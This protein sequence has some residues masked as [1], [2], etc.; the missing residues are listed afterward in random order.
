[1]KILRGTIFG[2]IAYFLLG[3]LVYGILLM[4]YFS[5]YTNTC[6]NRPEGEMIWWAI[7]LSN[8]LGALFLS[9]FLDRSRASRMADGLKTGGVFGALFT[10]T[11]NFSFWSMSIMYSSLLPLLVEIL[12][13]AIV[14]AIVG[15]IIVLTWGKA[16]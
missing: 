1:M 11:I 6:A 2:G 13:S 14:Y 16:K 10:A 5:S 8:L 7:I 15:M 12:V 3:W 9:L 4:D